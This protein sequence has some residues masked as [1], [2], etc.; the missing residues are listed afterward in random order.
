MVDSASEMSE[1]DTDAMSLSGKLSCD[2]HVNNVLTLK[3]GYSDS[4]RHSSRQRLLIEELTTRAATLTQEN[5]VLKV[6]TYAFIQ[7]INFA[8]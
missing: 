6:L 4:N 8:L 5:R 7:Y 1:S 2:G 3:L